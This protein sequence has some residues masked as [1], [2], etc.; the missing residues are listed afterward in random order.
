MPN[1]S[2]KRVLAVLNLTNKEKQPFI[3]KR[4]TILSI[5]LVEIGLP[6]NASFTRSLQNTRTI[7]SAI[8]PGIGNR[9][10]TKRRPSCAK[11]TRRCRGQ[12]EPDP[13]LRKDAQ[14]PDQCGRTTSRGIGFLV[15]RDGTILSMTEGPGV[16]RQSRR[17]C[18]EEHHGHPVLVQRR[19]LRQELRQ[20]WL[21]IAHTIPVPSNPQRQRH[22]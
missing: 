2:R 18:S 17:S 16:T 7:E 11:P 14:Q 5:M 1:Y 3:R 10:T 12:P 21:G 4:R 6:E 22:R 19:S 8:D 9:G 13:G 15:D 20:A